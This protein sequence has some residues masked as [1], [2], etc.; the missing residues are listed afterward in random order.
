MLDALKQFDRELFL[1]INGCH[2]ESVDTIMVFISGKFSWVPLYVFLLYL[3]IRAFQKRVPY[4]IV[5]VIILITLSDQGSVILFKN[6][7]QRL[8]PCHDES[9]KQLVHLVNGSCGGQ[10]GFISSHA[11]NTMAL[12]VFVFL[13]LK[14]NFGNKMSLIFLFP[15]IV[16]YSRVYLGIHYP[17]DVICGMIF[18]GILGYLIAILTQR[19]MPQ[20]IILH[21]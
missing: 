15:I 18:G 11:A 7:F 19:L 16:S 14:N 4:I 6:L 21:D 8:R 17:G 9:I 12:S 2:S 5:A 1:L 10:F 3:M 13:L 20:K